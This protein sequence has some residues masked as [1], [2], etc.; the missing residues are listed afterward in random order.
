MGDAGQ[1]D[2]DLVVLLGVVQAKGEIYQSGHGSSGGLQGKD[3][4]IS[5]QGQ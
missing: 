3:A 5:V 2:R 4:V 1:L